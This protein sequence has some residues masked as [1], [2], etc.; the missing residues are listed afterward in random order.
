MPDLTTVTNLINSPPGQ[1]VAGATLAGSIY[2]F[3]SWVEG[4]LTDQTKK[5]IARW[6][7]VRN[8]DTGLLAQQIEPWPDTFA[9]IFD[10]AFGDKHLS[11]KCFGRSCLASFIVS[12]L[13]VLLLL[14]NV[15]FSHK[16][17]YGSKPTFEGL[18]L[19]IVVVN[20]IPDYL[21]LV[22]TRQILRLFRRSRSLILWLLL[23]V[24][25]TVVTF[26]AAFIAAYSLLLLLFLLAYKGGPHLNDLLRP[27]SK[28]ASAYFDLFLD[29]NVAQGHFSVIRMV[30]E[31]KFCYPAFFT[32]IWLWLYAGSGFLLK[33]ANRF[34]LGFDWFNRKFDIEK[35]PLSAIGLVSGA[36]VAMLYWSWA[37]VRH[38]YPA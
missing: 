35:K 27:V 17:F 10:R 36:I 21:S 22:G 38:F 25:D 11:W 16:P 12:A 7:K 32:S 28:G 26:L 13:I 6:L 2:K 8:V 18:F 5:E 20:V 23:L 9:K 33:F 24:I 3:F 34:D 19:S 29:P 1:L 15:K 30:R 4:V 14:A 37:L 31:S